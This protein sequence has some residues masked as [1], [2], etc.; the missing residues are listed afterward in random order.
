ML[1]SVIVPI[2]N[3][4]QYVAR[5]LDCLLQQDLTEDEYEILIMDDGSSDQ[6]Y[7]IAKRYADRF[8]NIYLFQQFNSGPCIARNTL[9]NRARG[10]YIYCLDADDLIAFDALGV[11]VRLAKE[12]SLDI[13]GFNTLVTQ[14]IESFE[15][16]ISISMPSESKICSGY[17]YLERN[18]SIRFEIWWY[19]VKTSLLRDHHINFGENQYNGDVLFTLK[20]FSLAKRIAHIP[21]AVHCYFQ[22]KGSIMRNTENR[23]RQVLLGSLH[24][25]IRNF[26][27]FINQLEKTDVP[28][29]NGVVR[30][31]KNRRN[32]FVGS[33]LLKLIR[34]NLDSK[35]AKTYL[36]QLKEIKVYPLKLPTSRK[37]PLAKRLVMHTL[38]N[39]S[40]LLLVL[41]Y[42]RLQYKLINLG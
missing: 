24:M 15:P 36:L 30:N 13:I 38:N 34:S 29:T 6:S 19:I 41:T 11:L 37:A 26:T 1:L 33:F 22:S 18:P 10:E 40:L 35:Q 32:V 17:Q 27:N 14:R 23:H 2:F 8:K 16:I 25:M 42:K 21:I 3:V 31:L 28:Q 39:E 7:T 12:H 20:T 4:D 9:L 5:C